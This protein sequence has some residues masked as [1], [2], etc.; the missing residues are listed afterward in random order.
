MSASTRVLIKLQSTTTLAAVSPK[1]NLRPLYEE[2]TAG[3]GLGLAPQPA[4][5]LADLPDGGPTPWDAAHTQVAAQLGL[6]PTDVLYVEP[7]LA[8]QI[9]R[10]PHAPE[11]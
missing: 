1:V 2:P 5:F 8:H 10:G 7:D 4:W 11:R 3:I 6:A 9:F